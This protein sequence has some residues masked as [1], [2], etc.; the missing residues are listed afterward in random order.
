MTRYAWVAIVD[1]EQALADDLLD[2]ATLAGRSW[3]DVLIDNRGGGGDGGD[4]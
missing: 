4:Q 3:F 2:F 1:D